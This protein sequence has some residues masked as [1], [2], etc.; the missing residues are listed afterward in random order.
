[1]AFNGATISAVAARY[2][3]LW[4]WNGQLDLTKLLMITLKTR[5]HDMF[6]LMCRNR[7]KL[8]VK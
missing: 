1:M 2:G 7:Q 8:N 3:Q 5:L 4:G 6:F